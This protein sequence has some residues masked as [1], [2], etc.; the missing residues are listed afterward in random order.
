MMIS[1]GKY[2]LKIVLSCK[3][4]FFPCSI[5]V[6]RIIS[7]FW[8]KSGALRVTH[9]FIFLKNTSN[10]KRKKFVIFNYL[11]LFGTMGISGE[12]DCSLRP[13]VAPSSDFNVSSESFYLGWTHCVT[14]TQYIVATAVHLHFPEF[15]LKCVLL[16]KKSRALHRNMFSLLCCSS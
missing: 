8:G 12:E 7:I 1:S 16:L 13:T 6:N 10:T 9:S 4:F 14:R 5:Y 15:G 11:R 3:C 2:L